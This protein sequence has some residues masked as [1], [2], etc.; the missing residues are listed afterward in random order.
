MSILSTFST[1]ALEKELICEIVSE[2]DKNTSD[3]DVIS[4]HND[5]KNQCDAKK[6]SRD[7]III[8]VSPI[9]FGH[10][11]L[12][13]SLEETLPQILTESSIRFQFHYVLC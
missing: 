8:N 11:L 9:E 2:D 1:A 4:N 5:A 10:C 7:V 12:V 13:P 6:H 3:C